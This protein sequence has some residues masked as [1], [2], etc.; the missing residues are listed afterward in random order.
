M[1]TAVAAARAK[2]RPGWVLEVDA[3]AFS[4]ILRVLTILLNY[5]LILVKYEITMWEQGII[6]NTF[7]LAWRSNFGH[8]TE[9]ER[10][11]GV[12]EHFNRDKTLFPSYPEGLKLVLTYM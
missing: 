3:V 2:V 6:G 12:A 4:A 9:G 10:R 11:D 7:A 1:G 8:R 5:V